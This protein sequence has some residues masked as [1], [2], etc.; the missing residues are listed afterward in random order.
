MAIVALIVALEDHFDIEVDEDDVSGDI[1]ETVGTLA[2][3][4]DSQR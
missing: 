4:V 2:E 3:F 1:F